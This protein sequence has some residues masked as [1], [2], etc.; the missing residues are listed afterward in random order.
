MCTGYI[1]FPQL[2]IVLVCFPP[3]QQHSLF[4]L[5]QHL[6]RSFFKF[7]ITSHLIYLNSWAIL[8]A[9]CPLLVP[10]LCKG[11]RN[12]NTESIYIRF[13]DDII[14]RKHSVLQGQMFQWTKCVFGFYEMFVLPPHF[15]NVGPDALFCE[16]AHT[17]WPH[18]WTLWRNVSCCI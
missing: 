1:N 5:K 2:V 15:I 3:G 9:V 4:P 12:K 8:L 10:K 6:L 17:A 13:T 18:V 14:I 7:K 11:G 16:T